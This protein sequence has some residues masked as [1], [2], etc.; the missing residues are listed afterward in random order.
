MHRAMPL[1]SNLQAY[2]AMFGQQLELDEYGI[3]YRRCPDKR[4]LLIYVPECARETILREGHCIPVG[5]H[6][7]PAKMLERL[8]NHFFWD[9]MTTDVH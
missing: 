7:S 2:L 6:I 4:K 8:R 5:S 9:T 3:L 1:E